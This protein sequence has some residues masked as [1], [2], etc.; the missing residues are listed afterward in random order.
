MSRMVPM[1]LLAGAVLSA[2]ASGQIEPPK[3]PAAAPAAA[4]AA[5]NA[6]V[7]RVYKVTQTVTLNDIPEKAKSVRW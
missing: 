7:T 1:S 6:T 3:A 5:S 4:A 2:L